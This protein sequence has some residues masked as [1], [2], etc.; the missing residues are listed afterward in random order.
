MGGEDGEEGDMDIAALLGGGGGLGGGPPEMG[1][2]GEELG[3]MSADYD[4]LFGP[5]ALDGGAGG[6]EGEDG[7]VGDQGP[8]APDFGSDDLEDEDE[9]ESDDDWDDEDDE[10]EDEDEESDSDDDDSKAAAFAKK[11]SKKFMCVD[12]DGKD[13]CDDKETVYSKKYMKAGNKGDDLSGLTT[14]WMKKE[15][16]DFYNSIIGAGK[17]EVHQKFNSG[18]SAPKKTAPRQPQAGEVGYAPQG[19][20]G[21]LPSLGQY[22]EWKKLQVKKNG[23][24]LLREMGNGVFSGEGMW[25]DDEVPS[26]KRSLAQR[27]FQVERPNKPQRQFAAAG[28]PPGR[29]SAED[30]APGSDGRSLVG[31]KKPAGG[32]SVDAMG[33]IVRPNAPEAAPAAAP[34]G[35]KLAQKVAGCQDPAKLAA[36]MKILM[37]ESVRQRARRTR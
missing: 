16:A 29:A 7:P 5:G 2:D 1:D 14:K 11:K 17:G 13:H 37:G 28:G 4:D 32:G 15:D 8:G 3:D 36:I 23:T 12:K 20:V 30:M 27:G 21:N 19:R 31:A 26:P 34:D 25:T 10:E 24:K 22:N 35:A 33:Q 6:E 9:E 18:V